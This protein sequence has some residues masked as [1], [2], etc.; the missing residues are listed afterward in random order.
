MKGLLRRNKL[1]FIGAIVGAVT[2]F[3][4]WKF[5]GC[6]TGSCAITS[7]PFRSTIY[8]AVMGAL[9]AG[10]FIKQNKPTLPKAGEDQ[11]RS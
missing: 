6:V 2:G 11:V 3:L 4:Y 1:Y 9:I 10:L 7:N 8:F 5:I